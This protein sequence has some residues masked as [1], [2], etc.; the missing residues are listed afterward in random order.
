MI[1]PILSVE[2]IKRCGSTD[3]PSLWEE[4]IARFHRCILLYVLRERR[5]RGLTDNEEEAVMDL[6]QK[7]YMR[8]LANG[9]QALR[10]FRADGEQGVLFYLASIA[11]DVVGEQF[12]Y[13]SRQRRSVFPTFSGK[14]DD[15]D[16]LS[17][18]LCSDLDGANAVR[19][20]IIFQLHVIE[21]LSAREIAMLPVFRTTLSEVEEVIRH[22]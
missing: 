1:R 7:V 9:R 15:K 8:L 14:A 6:A 2:L 17:V 11:R 13:G 20:A 21:G 5:S 4:F 19:D 10:E 22:T 12:G 3:D 16:R 18:S